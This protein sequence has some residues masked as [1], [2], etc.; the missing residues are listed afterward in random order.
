MK[1]LFANQV[2]EFRP[3][4]V[5][6]GRWSFLLP[7]YGVFLPDP[8]EGTLPAGWRRTCHSGKSEIY[9]YAESGIDGYKALAKYW[10]VDPGR[11]MRPTIPRTLET[12]Q[13][14]LVFSWWY[15]GNLLKSSKNGL[16]YTIYIDPVTM[17]QPMLVPYL[18]SVMWLKDPVGAAIVAMK[19]CTKAGVADYKGSPNNTV[20]V[21]PRRSRDVRVMCFD[22][23]DK[24]DFPVQY[25]EWDH[26]HQN[27]P[28]PLQSAVLQ[29]YYHR[30]V[31]NNTRTYLR[32]LFEDNPASMAMI[33]DERLIA[34][35]TNRPHLLQDFLLVN[36][37]DEHGQRCVLR[38]DEEMWLPQWARKNAKIREAIY[39][40]RRRNRNI[41]VK[42]LEEKSLAQAA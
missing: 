39:T 21:T 28:D 8:G 4:P 5:R 20:V 23:T 19:R 9:H 30:M 37:F 15:R 22:P 29:L 24:G 40:A 3:I 42:K 6:G 10:D 1:Y 16:L 38:L 17:S 35:L 18:S 25:V 33:D 2:A 36:Y 31:K 13:D 14:R 12:D 26:D 34:F 32:R 27:R 11:I 41:H 7:Q